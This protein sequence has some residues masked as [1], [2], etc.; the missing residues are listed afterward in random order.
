MTEIHVVKHIDNSRLVKELDYQQTKECLLLVV[1]G[2]LCLLTLLFL[3]WQQFEVVRR[4]YE[5][6]DLRMELNLLTEANN[7]YKVERA[8]L[9]E[10]ERIEI[11]AREQLGLQFPSFQQVVIIEE[12]VSIKSREVLLASGEKDGFDSGLTN[13]EAVQ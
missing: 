3:A 2:F 5:H 4:G 12:P 8:Q 7:S 10:P 1:L 6:E 11:Y 9:K 13:F